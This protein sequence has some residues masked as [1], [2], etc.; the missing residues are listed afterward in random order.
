MRDEVEKWL[1]PGIAVGVDDTVN[2][3]ADNM[4]GSID[5]LISQVET[6]EL[7]GSGMLTSRLNYFGN[8][9]WKI[10]SLK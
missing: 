3:T 4:N 5:N 10:I 6:L 9:R 2:Q 7:S 8:F 1:L